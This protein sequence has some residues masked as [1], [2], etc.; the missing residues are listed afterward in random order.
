[1]LSRALL[2]LGSGSD[3][4]EKQ[5][6]RLISDNE[7]ASVILHAHRP[8]SSVIREKPLEIVAA[9]VRV[10]GRGNHLYETKKK[11]TMLTV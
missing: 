6:D 2:A 7:I 3:A 11:K 10:I 9:L 8:G 4:V 1:M 5:R